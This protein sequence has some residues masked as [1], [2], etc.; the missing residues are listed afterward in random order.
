MLSGW[1]GGTGNT[2]DRGGSGVG[3]DAYIDGCTRIYER[4]SM[5]GLG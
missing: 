1:D 5:G 4:T 2:P 3:Q